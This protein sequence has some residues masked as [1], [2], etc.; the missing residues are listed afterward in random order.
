[1]LGFRVVAFVTSTLT[2]IPT[3]FDAK[4]GFNV[5]ATRTTMDFNCTKIKLSTS[6]LI[7]TT[8]IVCSSLTFVPKNVISIAPLECTLIY[9]GAKV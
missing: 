9:V 4:E 7:P 5:M 1:M 2:S 8:R 6:I 3:S